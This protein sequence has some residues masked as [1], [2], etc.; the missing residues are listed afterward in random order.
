M[1]LRRAGMALRPLAINTDG[2]TDGACPRGAH[3]VVLCLWLARRRA[4]QRLLACSSVERG[5]DGGVHRRFEVSHYE[6]VNVG[7]D[8]SFGNPGRLPLRAR[9]VFFEMTST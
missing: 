9:H 2:D 1:H 8:N 6:E 7:V 5:K 4:D 3:R